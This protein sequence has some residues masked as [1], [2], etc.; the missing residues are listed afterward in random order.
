MPHDRE[1]QGASADDSVE[2]ERDHLP[3]HNI[4]RLQQFAVAVFLQEAETC[5]ITP[6]RHAVLQAIGDTPGIDQRDRA[7]ASAS[8]PPP[9]AACSTA[10]KRT[11]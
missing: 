4:R 8:T 9:S 1:R 3:G 5:G 7:R 11:A 6:V 2:V 10:S